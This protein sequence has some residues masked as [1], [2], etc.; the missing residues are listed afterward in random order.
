MPA[1]PA[2]GAFTPFVNQGA[3]SQ[4]V[5]VVDGKVIPV[6]PGSASIKVPAIFGSNAEEGTLFI[7]G[8]YGAASLSLNQSAYDE[9]LAYN[10]GPLASEVNETYS[11]D[12]FNGS[13][14]T[15]MTAVFTDVAYKCPSYRGLLGAQAAGMPVWTYEF[16]HAP[17]CAWYSAIPQEY[18]SFVG[19]THTAEIPFVFNTTHN[20]PLPGGNCTFSFQEIALAGAMS[21]VWTDMAEYGNV[22]DEALWP[23]WSNET[24][25]GVNIGDS[26]VVGVVD[27][28][29]CLF[30]DEIH[31]ESVKIAQ[32][33]SKT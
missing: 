21:R 20:M 5:P 1:D 29:T 11:V 7:L 17:S 30:W 28:S 6:A 15:A 33:C 9:F 2:P 26:M 3:R 13:V 24:G 16:N 12:K 19:A 22:G 8:A 27:Y 23:R 14:L 18:V 32:G 4:W 31:A 10:F 25:A